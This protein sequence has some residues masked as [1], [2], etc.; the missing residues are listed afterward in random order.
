MLK[1]SHA[2]NDF[3]RKPVD[4]VDGSKEGLI[5]VLERHGCLSKES[6]PDFNDVSVLALGRAVLLV[7]MGA[8][9]EVGNAYFREEGI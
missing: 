5:L 2:L 8:R 7:C 3:T 9:D 6:K 4:E 1:R